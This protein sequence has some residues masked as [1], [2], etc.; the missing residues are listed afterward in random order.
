[1][2]QPE[3]AIAAAFGL[4]RPVDSLKPVQ[5]TSFQ[6]WRLQTESADFLLKR[7]WG[8]DDP[9]WQP[10]IAKGMALEADALA[11]GLPIVRPVTPVMPA[12]GYAARINDFGTVR[13]YDWIEHRTVAGSD[14]L[15]S[16]LATRRRNPARIK[17]AACR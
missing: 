11:R 6:T 17:T 1:M 13:L 8:L 10:S 3:A 14:D 12:F 4:P 7:L 5:H 15:T 9:P 16:W 2:L